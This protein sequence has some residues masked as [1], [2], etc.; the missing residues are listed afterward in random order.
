MHNCV[1][2]PSFSAHKFENKCNQFAMKKNFNF[3]IQGSLSKIWI[4]RKKLFVFKEEKTF[5]GSIYFLGQQ[6][7]FFNPTKSLWLIMQEYI[8]EIIKLCN[9]KFCKKNLTKCKLT[10]CIDIMLDHRIEYTKKTV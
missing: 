2:F 5:F 10:I 6:V 8:F 3:T 1:P 7:Y 4:E 9:S